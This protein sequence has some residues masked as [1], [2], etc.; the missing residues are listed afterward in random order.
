M[1]LSESTPLPWESEWDSI[2]LKKM[3]PHTCKWHPLAYVGLGMVI[4]AQLSMW[5]WL[6]ISDKKV[7]SISLRSHENIKKIH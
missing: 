5:R 7:Y 1:A 3:V 4:I 6:P 2:S